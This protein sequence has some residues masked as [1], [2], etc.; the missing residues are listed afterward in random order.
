MSSANPTRIYNEFLLCIVPDTVCETL[1]FHSLTICLFQAF[2]ERAL[3]PVG[4]TL[5][6]L[7]R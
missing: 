1:P 6:P 3:D 5:L 4:L 7:V 2:K